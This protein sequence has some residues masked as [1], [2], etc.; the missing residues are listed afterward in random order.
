[1]NQSKDLNTYVN[2]DGKEYTIVPYSGEYGYDLFQK[3]MVTLGPGA[4]KLFK[5][6][7]LEGDEEISEKKV[8]FDALEDGIVTMLMS[9]NGDGKAL[10]KLM[11]DILINTMDGKSS[12][13]VAKDFS[14][15]FE[16]QY[17]HGFKL[18]A[19]T[20]KEQYSDF[21]SGLGGLKTVLDKISSRK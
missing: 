8:N 20:L 15:R 11:K 17:L 4:A 14:I 6:V 10:T 2:V 18:C 12:N 7:D 21:L 13:S 1:M 3:L 9:F 16:K 19:V 5:V